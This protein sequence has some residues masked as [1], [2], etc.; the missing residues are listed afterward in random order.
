MTTGASYWESMEAI[1]RF[2]PFKQ[3]QPLVERKDLVADMKRRNGLP[4]KSPCYIFPWEFEIFIRCGIGALYLIRYA[5]SLLTILL[6]YSRL[7]LLIKE[8][9][10]TSLHG[11]STTGRIALPLKASMLM[12]ALV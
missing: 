7:F 1:E 11:H 8:S 5:S 6:A 3:K 12:A 9:S 2:A 4:L 10:D